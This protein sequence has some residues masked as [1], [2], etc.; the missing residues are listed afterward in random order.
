V[1]G[2][3]RS[4]TQLWVIVEILDHRPGDG[5]AIIGARATADL[6]QD[7][8]APRG[9]VV[10]DVRELYHLHHE[11]AL[12]RGNLIL[13]A[14]AA[15]D[16]VHQAHMRALGRD[17]GTDLGHQCNE[18][19][20]PEIGRFATHVWARNE[21]NRALR[22]QQHVVGHK[23]AC[24]QGTFHHGMTGSL[25]HDP[26][27]ITQFGANVTVFS[28][29]LREG[30]VHIQM[31]NRLRRAANPARDAPQP[32]KQLTIELGLEFLRPLLGVKDQ[33]LA[34]LELWSD[35]SLGV[36]QRLFSDVFGRHG[37]RVG[38]GDLDIV[39]KYLI[40]TDLEALDACA[41]PFCCLQAGHPALCL[42]H[43]CIDPIA[44]ARVARLDD[45]TATQECRRIV[46]NGLANPRHCLY[47]GI[48]RIGHQRILLG[49]AWYLALS[50]Q[51]RHC[52]LQQRHTIQRGLQAQEVAWC[53]DTLNHPA[54]ET[55][56]ISQAV[57]G[58][59]ERRALYRGIQ[60]YLHRPLPA[61]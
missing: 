5:Y 45:A 22:I 16:P 32:I 33:G 9:G 20:H 36:D 43:G 47:A 4:R 6:I 19:D 7:E 25:E 31:G 14:D 24:G 51:S 61:L 55:G 29:R 2:K 48:E 49:C 15:K 37:I 27:A 56:K 38:A 41:S 60:A 10:E 1:G 46:H 39:A 35:V 8:Q 54:T 26:S 28:R 21:V 53:R 52:L 23:T 50:E 42:G 44:F 59:P 11:G 58:L 3:E 13:R 40:E 57:Q 18:G 30:K 34:L 12:A 17:K